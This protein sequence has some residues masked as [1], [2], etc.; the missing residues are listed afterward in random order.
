MEMTTEQQPS[1]LVS[2][3]SAWRES[4]GV[5]PHAVLFPVTLVLF[6]RS[7]CKR[8]CK[9]MGCSRDSGLNLNPLC[10]QAAPASAS[11]P[12]SRAP[13]LCMSSQGSSLSPSPVS[14]LSLIKFISL[15]VALSPGQGPS[16]LAVSPAPRMAWPL[17]GSE[18][19]SVILGRRR[20]VSLCSWGWSDLCPQVPRPL[21][22]P[23][24]P[25]FPERPPRHVAA[26]FLGGRWLAPR[27]K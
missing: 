15:V 22:E 8:T 1:F 12:S 16:F 19:D 11:Q 9:M 25:E 23:W 3:L 13:G 5:E 10:K 26:G 24:R 7:L 27:R 17:K 18:P 20:R 4:A 6:R 21:P 2:K 14:A